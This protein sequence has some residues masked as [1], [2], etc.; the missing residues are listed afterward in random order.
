MTVREVPS[1]QHP[2]AQGSGVREELNLIGAME[3]PAIFGSEGNGTPHAVVPTTILQSIIASQENLEN[4]VS[5]LRTQGKGDE[6]VAKKDSG[7]KQ[8]ATLVTTYDDTPVTQAELHRLL[9]AERG[10]GPL[11]CKETLPE[12]DLVYGCIKNIE[13]GSQILLS[14]GGIT[15]FVELMRRGVDVTEAIKRQ[16]KRAKEADN[17]F[18]V[19][20]L[21][22]KGR[23]RNF[24][25]PH[26]SREYAHNNEEDL[27]PLPISRVQ[28]C[29]L[30][31]EWL[32]DG[33]IQLKGNKTPLSK[34]QYDDPSY[35]ILHKTRYH[36]TMN[37]WTIRRAF[38]RQ[39]KAGKVLLPEGGGEAGDL[40][41]RPLPDH[42]LGLDQE[43]Q[44]EAAR[45]LTKIIKEK[46]GELCAANE[47]LMRLTR[48]HATT[49]L[50]KEPSPQGP[51]F[52]HNRPLYVESRVEG[53]ELQRDFGKEAKG[54]REGILAKWASKMEDPIGKRGFE[55]ETSQTLLQPLIED[56]PQ[57]LQDAPK[58]GEEELEEV[59]VG[60]GA[61]KRRPLFISKVL[62]R[63]EKDKMTQFLREFRDVFA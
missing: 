9:Q 60:E 5:D 22:E 49:I 28:A 56:A 26:P 29:Q 63:D 14:L 58:Q 37:C 3:T 52:C 43:A 55:G 8:T 38:Q 2:K 18:D 17:T 12:A 15:T 54:G 32:K 42:G 39:F 31:E 47:L 57:E 33:T 13:D 10:T 21:E 50:F 6:G 30:V 1:L 20:A 23:K 62:T 27:P 53:I 46:G 36:T 40:H 48:S 7:G 25:G 11:Q 35:C 59:D 34:E 4:L 24:R 41:R 19:S 44:K 45:A 61:D 16:G 51:E